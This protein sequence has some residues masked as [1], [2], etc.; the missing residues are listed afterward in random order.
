MRNLAAELK[1]WLFGL[2]TAV[3]FLTRLPLPVRIEWTPAVLRRSLA[4]YPVVGMILGLLLTGSG[5][6]LEKTLPPLPA[7]ALLLCLWIGLTGA[8][9]L[10]GLMDTA[11]GLLSHRSRERMLEIMK[12]SRVGA[13]GVI[14][15]VAVLLLKWSVMVPLLTGGALTG[16]WILLLVPVWSRTFMAAAVALWPYARSG[17]GLGGFFEGEKKPFALLG[18]GVALFLS[19]GAVAFFHESGGTLSLKPSLHVLE[20]AG[21][22]W[23]G[24][25]LLMVTFALG[26]VLAAWMAKKLG[27]L[28]G[29][30]YGALN[31]LLEA[32]LLL[33]AAFVL[34]LT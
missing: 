10:D 14:V 33:A 8:L 16:S 5:W 25:M 27:G 30:T 15:C 17:G 18:A 28:T 20:G 24:I 29:D 6:V 23:W 32:L 2:I 13:M 19:A 21:P 7:A 1:L 9:H 11:D 3:Q 34:H 31:E 4:F 22:V 12:D 26:G